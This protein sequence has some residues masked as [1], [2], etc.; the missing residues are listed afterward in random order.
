MEKTFEFIKESYGN[1]GEYL[2]AIGFTHQHQQR[3]REA[4]MVDAHRGSDS[5]RE[6]S[7]GE[8][9][10][11]EN[12]DE[13][14]EQKAKEDN[15]DEYEGWTAGRAPGSDILR[16]SGKPLLKDNIVRTPQGN[17]ASAKSSTF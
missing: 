12:D 10:E 2:V 5:D 4:L 14:E 13:V 6:G 3:L 11:E 1:V 15:G 9:E 17:L 7:G 16:R 8:E